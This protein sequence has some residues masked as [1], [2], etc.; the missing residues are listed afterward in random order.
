MLTA[1][2]PIDISSTSK[3][4]STYVL[5]TS[6]TNRLLNKKR[7]CQNVEQV[8]VQAQVTFVVIENLDSVHQKD[9]NIWLE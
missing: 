6:T 2:V 8:M 4:A 9:E 7:G 1:Y 3:T 5:I